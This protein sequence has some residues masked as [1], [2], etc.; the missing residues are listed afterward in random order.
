LVAA[1]VALAL[2]L[3]TGAGL[4]LQTLWGMQHVDRGFSVDRIGVATISLPGST[5]RTPD[6]VRAFYARLLS[7]VRALP[8]VES[9]ALTTGVLQ[10]LLANSGFIS[11][12]GKPL[13]PPEERLEYPAEIVSP[14]F[15]ETIG[16]RMAR[17]REFTD[18][19]HERTAP[20]VIVNE[21]LANSV[22]PGEDPIGRRLRRGDGANG[23]P[24][25]TVVGVVKDL[26]RADVKRNIRPEVYFSSLQTPPRTETLVVR[27]AGD[28]NAIMAGVRRE[29]QALDPQLPLFRVSTLA[30]QVSG[31]LSQPRFQATLLGGF[32]IIALLLAA[33]GIYG[34][35]SH[36]VSQR[37]QE[38]GIRM[39][40]GARHSDV[41]FLIL[42]QHVSPAIVGITVG[43][44]GAVALSRFLSS[45]L[46]G[47]RAVDPL[48]YVLVTVALM[49]VAIAA[50]WIPASRAM[51]VDPLVALRPE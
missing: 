7:K 11:F 9:A 44:M 15:F 41:R 43:I 31:T 40:M 51:R 50:C 24:W 13:P 4:L 18:Q 36:A 14:G 6:D 12:E 33:I 25:I 46:Y 29:I 8:G 21:T 42:R 48:T 22:W 49:G 27:S 38:V 39:A 26:R 17:G 34:V 1:E 23:Q 37:T 2:I 19:D 35:T 16:A 28:P 45:L 3:L 20:V 5:Y 10:P 30:S 32:A 47:V